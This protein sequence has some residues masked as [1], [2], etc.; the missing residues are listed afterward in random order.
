MKRVVTDLVNLKG[1]VVL[2][3]VDFNVPTDKTGRILDLS[4]VIKALPTIKH[5]I[6]QEAKVVLLSHMGRP[7]GYEITHSLWQIAL[8]LM[9][10]L[11]TKVY[12]NNK[13]IGPEVREQI[14]GM[15]NGSVLL[16][17]NVRFYEEE[18]ANDKKFA[19][20]IASMGDIFV[21]DAFGC[22]HRKHASVYGVARLLPNAIGLLMQKEIQTLTSVM[23]K[24]KR[25]FVAVIGG[26]K[27]PDK[28]G[29][30]KVFVDKADTILIGGAMAYTFLMA[31]PCLC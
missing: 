27:V 3:R 12:F 18:T 11:N 20:E 29:L 22:S 1:K 19:Q 25:P 24:P 26:A 31:K 8:I 15:G 10:K 9:Q 21:N 2:L 14:K 23:E 30:L 4:R 17:E 13:V 5:L 16:L 6:K 28:I 7:K